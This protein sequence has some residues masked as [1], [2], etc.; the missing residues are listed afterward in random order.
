MK[1]IVITIFS[2]LCLIYQSCAMK[3]DNLM[4]FDEQA[5]ARLL[6]ESANPSPKH[7]LKHQPPVTSAFIGEASKRR[8]YSP[9]DDD[10][11]CWECHEIW[12]KLSLQVSYTPE[13][14]FQELHQFHLGPTDVAADSSLPFDPDIRRREAASDQRLDLLDHVSEPHSWSRNFASTSFVDSQPHVALLKQALFT[15]CKKFVKLKISDL[16]KTQFYSY[17][18]DPLNV[19]LLVDKPRRTNKLAQMA[20]LLP[21]PDVLRLLADC[22]EVFFLWYE[23][24]LEKIYELLVIAASASTKDDALPSPPKFGNVGSDFNIASMSPAAVITDAQLSFVRSQLLGSNSPLLKPLALSN[25]VFSRPISTKFSSSFAAG[26]VHIG[27]LNTSSSAIRPHKKMKSL[28]AF[29]TESRCMLLM[30]TLIDFLLAQSNIAKAERPTILTF[31]KAKHGILEQ[32]KVLLLDFALTRPLSKNVAAFPTPLV[33]DSYEGIM[34]IIR[35]SSSFR[36]LVFHDQKMSFPFVEVPNIIGRWKPADVEPTYGEKLLYSATSIDVNDATFSPLYS[37]ISTDS[38]QRIKALALLRIKEIIENPFIVSHPSFLVTLVYHGDRSAQLNWAIGI[39]DPVDTLT[40]T[41]SKPLAMAF[42]DWYKRFI[43]AFFSL[44]SK[45]SAKSVPKMGP[46]S[47]YGCLSTVRGLILEILKDQKPSM[48]HSID[49]TYRAVLQ[50]SLE[51]RLHRPAEVDRRTKLAVLR[52]LII[53]LFA[54]LIGISWRHYPSH[55]TLQSE[56]LPT[57]NLEG[58]K[59]ICCDVHEGLLPPY[60]SSARKRLRR[61]KPRRSSQSLST[62]PREPSKPTQIAPAVSYNSPKDLERAKDPTGDRLSSNGQGP[63]IPF[64]PGM[65]VIYHAQN[66]ISYIFS[67]FE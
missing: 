65:N 12:T 42:I 41:S 56:L 3:A 15:N 24:L 25:L 60:A 36:D 32:M 26:D 16:S 49:L 35:H 46:A 23:A 44:M 20:P 57:L 33:W 47:A 59:R 53:D 63:I 10:P 52:Q 54:A 66:L 2:A 28:S 51:G 18:V 1:F 45:C 5:P 37:E 29:L 30:I 55:Y 40:T 38:V 31:K 64:P 67:L 7:S 22:S 8:H 58:L 27:S 62:A 19:L 4:V 43:N 34:A 61:Q 14:L 13:S 11:F 48:T 9:S 6:H 21:V 39:Q 50:G 17:F